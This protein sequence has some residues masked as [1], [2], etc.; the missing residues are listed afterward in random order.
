MRR[1]VLAAGALA[2]AACAVKLSFGLYVLALVFALRRTPRRAAMLVGAGLAVG[3]LAYL[4][5]GPDAF[6]QA[7]T[8]SKFVSFAVPL[9]IMVFP[10]EA[11]LG[12]ETTRALIGPIAL[13][14]LAVF[15]ILLYR[16]LRPAAAR[17][18]SRGSAG[19]EARET[20]DAVAAA[21]A[22][23][24]AWVLTAPY[25]L[26]WYDVVVW[27]PLTLLAATGADVLLVAR[28]TVLTCAYLPGRVMALPA[29]LATFGGAVR[30]VVAPAAGLALLV[31]VVRLSRSAPGTGR[32]D[33]P[34]ATLL[35]NGGGGPAP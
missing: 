5:V 11:L 6:A 8:A 30:G 13:L 27:A 34:R 12:K 35:R 26:P 23:T 9:R 19:P 25:S 18:P 15:A 22:L 1:R 10:L 7:R 21:A 4:P 32:G 24:F 29:G 16:L 2:G 31:A 14:L 20:P 17:L 28:T 3:A 33:A